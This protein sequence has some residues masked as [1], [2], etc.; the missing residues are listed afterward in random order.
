MLWLVMN[1]GAGDKGR[2]VHREVP[3]YK[4]LQV[5][6]VTQVRGKGHTKLP[7]IVG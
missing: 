3:I 6:A 2:P 5:T 4:A 1:R 7:Y